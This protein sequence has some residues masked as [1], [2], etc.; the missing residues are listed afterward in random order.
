MSAELQPPDTDRA[1]GLE[2]YATRSPGVAGT[3]KANADAFRVREISAYPVPDPDGRFVVVRIKSRN[4]EQHEL[5]SALARR[6][7]LAPNAIRWAGT[8][9]RRAVTERLFSYV[10]PLP[11]ADIHLADATIL[12]AYRARDGLSLGH[13]YGNAFEIRVNGLPVS[14]GDAAVAYGAVRRELEEAGRFPDLF[15]LQRF[16]EVRPV[17]HDVGRALV[18]GRVGEAVE[19]YLARI[20][21]GD[22]P[23]RSPARAAYAADHDAA[24]ALQDFPRE[25]RFERSMLEHLARGH[26]PERAFRALNRELRLLF[27]HAYQSLL[28][29]R[30][31]S[32]RRSLAIPLEVPEEGDYVLRVGR[33]GTMRGQDAIPVDRDNVPE[34]ADLAQRGRAVVA[35]P[36]I[37]FETPRRPGRVGEL[38]DRLLAEEEVTTKQFEL[39]H[40]PD[41]SSAGTW[42]PATLALPPIGISPDP[43]GPDGEGVWFRFALPKG[44][45]AT[46][47]LREFLKGGASS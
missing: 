16:G 12:E 23:G 7:G 17:T 44:A 1:V 8:K 46:I 22:D 33:D 32:L 13:H 21:P 24:R 40:T 35:G 2:F 28:F 34:C 15:G 6:L 30:W 20:P 43:S 36:L 31:V 47:L 9:D 10:G 25:Y 4:W 14:A 27:V 29:N 38:L 39:P 37:G 11:E 26:P 42:R 5:A 45:Y 18:Q 41:I 3:L 19:I